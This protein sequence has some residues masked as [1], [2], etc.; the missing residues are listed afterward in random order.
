MNR[1]HRKLPCFFLALG[2]PF[3]ASLARP[4]QQ[5]QS[6]DQSSSQ[7]QT[8][9]QEK[10]DSVA[11]AARKAKAKKAAAPQSKVVTEDDLAGMNKSG[12]SVVG[13]EN[14]K[15]ATPL[16]AKSNDDKKYDPNSEEYWRSKSQPILD[17]MKAI[18]QKIAQLREDIKKMGPGG[19][20]VTTGFKDNVAYIEDRNGQIQTLEKR[21]ATLQKQLDD[22]EEEGRKAGAQPAWFR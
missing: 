7:S 11:E 14:N 2:W 22:L 12:V 10:T 16:T 1:I 19:F 8:P 9:A 17:Q 21:K 18:D 3:A 15:K 6:A 20:D 4:S 5:T 13:E